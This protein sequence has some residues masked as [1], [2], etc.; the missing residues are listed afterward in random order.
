MGS[1]ADQRAALRRLLTH[2]DEDG[3]A[4]A[5][6]LDFDG[7]VTDLFRGRST[8]P[9]ADRIKEAVRAFWGP[10][11]ADVESCDDSHGILRR[12]RD[13][14]DRPASAPR[15]PR[16]LLAAEKIV[17][18]YEYEVVET[19]D[20][21]PHALRLIDVL[22]DHGIPLVIVSNNADGPIWEFFKSAKVQRQ[23]KVTAVVGRDP[24]ELRNMKPDPD[25]VLRAVDLLGT[26]PGRCL[27]VGDQITD[28][29][30]AQRAGAPFLGYTQS[31][32]RAARMLDLGAYC[33]ARSHEPLI[34]AV[35]SL[36]RPN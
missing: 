13:M 33:V 36:S 16:A 24:L 27:L 17:T 26:R 30:A 11:D 1:A 9:V 23:E 2:P 3:R 5:V 34:N 18:A 19:A 35:E 8:A 6:L 32:E 7:P 25:S 10:L 14:Y 12:L 28:L 31:S 29:Q 4:G 15:D 20:P 21:A 22:A